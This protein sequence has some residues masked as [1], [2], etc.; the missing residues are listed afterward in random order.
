MTIKRISNEAFEKIIT[1]KFKDNTSCVIKF[2]SNSCPLCHGLRQEYHTIAESFDDLFFYAF[3]VDEY[4][5]VE[6]MVPIKGVPSIAFVK[7]RP[8]FSV[9]LLEDPPAEKAHEDMWYHPEQI[10]KFIKENIK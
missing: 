10:I 8:Q 6:R 1:G 5:H 9:N 3:N 2:Y 7:G 4:P